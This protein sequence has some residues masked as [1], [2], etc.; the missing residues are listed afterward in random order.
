[1]DPDIG[2]NL[3]HILSNE[4]TSS[5]FL[6]SRWCPRKYTERNTPGPQ[7]KKHDVWDFTSN[8]GSRIKAEWLVFVFMISYCSKQFCFREA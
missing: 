5:T 7:R 4:I 2:P 3:F 1:M 6:R 8:S